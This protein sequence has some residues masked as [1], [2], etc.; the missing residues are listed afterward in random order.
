MQE[1]SQEI[2]NNHKSAGGTGCRQRSLC[3]CRTQSPSASE[4]HTAPASESAPS[5][6][7]VGREGGNQT[8]WIHPVHILRCHQ[9]SGIFSS[10]PT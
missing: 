9:W 2:L 3:G 5:A 4:T 8:Q 1:G 10:V 7:E 6:P